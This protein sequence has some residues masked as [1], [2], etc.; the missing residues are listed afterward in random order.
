MKKFLTVMIAMAM[1]LSLTGCN[2]QPETVAPM[3]SSLESASG[4]MEEIQ[5]VAFDACLALTVQAGD[6]QLPLSITMVGQSS[7]DPRVIHADMTAGIKRAKVN[8]ELYAAEAG[9]QMITYT[10]MEL[11][12]QPSWVRHREDKPELTPLNG[13]KL[14]GLLADMEPS[15]TGTTI[16]GVVGDAYE[17]AITVQNVRKLLKA[18]TMIDSMGKT[19]EAA[20]EMTRILNQLDPDARIPVVSILDKEDLWLL[21]LRVDM[22][23]VCNNIARQEG[24][25]DV[26]TI[27]DFSFRLTLRD[28]NAIGPVEIPQEVLNA[29]EQ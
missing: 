23:E 3:D 11:L 18:L 20:E 24:N 29:P 5:T 4:K 15:G 13:A 6:L 22:T 10:G 26:F 19:A 1:T 8:M 7:E 2:S 17:G 28:H 12:G 9:D 14:I 25:S 21:E 16:D 27:A